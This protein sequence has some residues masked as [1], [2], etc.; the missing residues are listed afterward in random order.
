MCEMLFDAHNVALK[1][2]GVRLISSIYGLSLFSN[3][4]TYFL[5][6]PFNQTYFALSCVST[7][8]FTLM[9]LNAAM[10]TSMSVVEM[11]VLPTRDIVRFLLMNGGIIETPISQV[12]IKSIDRTRVTYVAATGQREY[13]V[14]VDLNNRYLKADYLNTEL[15]MAI[16]HKDVHSI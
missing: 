14:I 15:L 12:H 5:L 7:F 13:R 2:H 6:T 16:G 4:Y 3:Y 1:P 11:L 8:M 10:S 9:N